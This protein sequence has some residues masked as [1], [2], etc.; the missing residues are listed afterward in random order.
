MDKVGLMAAYSEPHICGSEYAATI[1]AKHCTRL[2]HDGS[3]VIRN[4]LEHF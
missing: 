4:I 1:L 2:P 3:S